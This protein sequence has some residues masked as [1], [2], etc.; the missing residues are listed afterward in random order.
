MQASPTIKLLYVTPEQL[1]CSEALKDILSRLTGRGKISLFVVDEVSICHQL[2]FAAP[3]SS[4]LLY[5]S[6]AGACCTA[7]KQAL[8]ISCCLRQGS[9]RSDPLAEREQA[10][11]HVKLPAT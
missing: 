6:R 4:M 9:A 3:V 1:A 5:S 10:C 11:Q 2:A 7:Y 8:C